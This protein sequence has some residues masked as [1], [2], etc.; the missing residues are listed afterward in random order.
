MK[1]IKTIKFFLLLICVIIANVIHHY[2]ATYTLYF[3]I[4]ASTL[5]VY[6]ILTKEKTI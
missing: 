1:N 4:P 3:A 5:L 2:A 6:L